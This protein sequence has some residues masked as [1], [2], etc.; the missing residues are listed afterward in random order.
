MVD[1]TRLL[2]VF[3]LALSV[4]AVFQVGLFLRQLRYMR[5]AAIDTRDAARAALMSA[6]TAREEFNA[7]HRPEIIVHGFEVAHDTRVDGEAVSANFVMVNK[8]TGDALIEKMEG[9]IV[10]GVH[11][12]RAGIT[13]E[14]LRFT[15]HTL[16]AGQHLENTAIFGAAGNVDQIE[17]ESGF[18]SA[19]TVKLWCIGRIT[20]NDQDGRQRRMGFCRVYNPKN[21]T[22]DRQEAS[23]Y[24]YSY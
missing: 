5:D 18:G 6:Q 7:A 23:D 22:W 15:P 17:F 16:A 8:G 21:K 2:A 1:W 24:E 13:L 3:T 4:V 20:Y 11:Y 9:I 14:D 19:T 10:P 12:L